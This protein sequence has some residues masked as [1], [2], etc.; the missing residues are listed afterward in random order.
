MIPLLTEIRS[1][2][3]KYEDRYLVGETFLSTPEKAVHYT[4]NDR[5]H[6]AFNFKLLEQPWNAQ[7]FSRQLLNGRS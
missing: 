5:L 4:G 2:L 1:L 6:A 3:D 7:K